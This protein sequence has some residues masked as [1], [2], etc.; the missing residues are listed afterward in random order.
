MQCDM[1]WQVSLLD[2]LE[3]T[4]ACLVLG[5]YTQVVDK[6]TSAIIQIVSS[7]INPSS[8]D[9]EIKQGHPLATFMSVLGRWKLLL[10]GS[11]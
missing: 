6:S 7:I 9:N 8:L 1:L 10:S 4:H 5:S 11:G 3:G 2:K